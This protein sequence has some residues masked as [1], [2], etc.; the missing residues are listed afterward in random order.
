MAAQVLGGLV[1]EATTDEA[2]YLAKVQTCL[3]ERSTSSKPVVGDVI[4]LSAKRSALRT[5]IEGDPVTV[6]LG[7]SEKDAKRVFD[8]YTSVAKR[9]RSR[10]PA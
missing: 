3:T 7:G 4:A 6:A 2:S 5:S 10:G 1:R 9:G 8:A